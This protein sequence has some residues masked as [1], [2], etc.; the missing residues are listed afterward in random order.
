MC[1]V[2]YFSKGQHSHSLLHSVRLSLPPQLLLPLVF[3]GKEEQVFPVEAKFD[4]LMSTPVWI[5]PGLG[6]CRVPS[7][8]LSQEGSVLLRGSDPTLMCPR[9]DMDPPGNVFSE[10]P[11]CAGL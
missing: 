6:Q 10:L 3:S 8:A 7:T 11:W 5:C 9:A 4:G 2:M 1:V